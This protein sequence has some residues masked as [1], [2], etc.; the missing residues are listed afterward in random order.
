MPK[1]VR[2]DRGNRPSEGLA[3]LARLGVDSGGTLIERTND[4]GGA[5]DRALQRMACIYSL[6][7]RDENAS[8]GR[9]RSVAVR[10]NRPDLRAVHAGA[11]TLRSEQAQ[12][13]AALRAAHFIPSEPDTEA[14]RATLLPLR[15]ASARE[16]RGQIALTFALHPSAVAEL[17]RRDPEFG[18]VLSRGA[19]VVHRVK[20]RVRLDP[21]SGESATPVVMT[22]LE[23]VELPGGTYALAAVLFDPAAPAPRSVQ[24]SVELPEVPRGEPFLVGPVLGRRGGASVVIRSDGSDPHTGAPRSGGDEI[25]VERASGGFE[26][27]VG[28]RLAEPTDVVVLTQI[29]VVGAADVVTL[30]AVTRVLRSAAGLVLGE[31]EPV[32]ASLDGSGEVRCA[33]LVD[34]VPAAALR[35]GGDYLFEAA[36]A[37]EGGASRPAGTAHFSVAP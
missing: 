25:D 6:A 30:P 9:R 33:N 10:L 21:A 1:S 12:Y 14:F 35:P 24:L 31:L 27:L 18:I 32:R 34:V 11:Y 4:V 29:C 15:P 2:G 16:W 19:S 37:V 13:E 5:M 8:D 23:P 28:P 7:F 20:R 17:E 22:F 26:P 36:L 3:S